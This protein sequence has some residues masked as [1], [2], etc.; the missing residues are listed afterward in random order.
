M[1]KKV[2]AAF[3]LMMVLPLASQAI[4]LTNAFVTSSTG[5]STIAVGDTITY[6]VSLSLTDGNPYVIGTFSLTGDILGTLPSTKGSGWLGVENHVSNWQW[7]YKSGGSNQVKFATNGVIT[8]AITVAPHG[9]ER[10]LAQSYGIFGETGTTGNGQTK[11]MGTVTITASTSGSYLGGAFM[12]PLVDS[13][14]GSA[15]SEVAPIEGAAFTVIPEPGT[16]LL[17]LLGLG[18]LGVMGRKK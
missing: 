9:P 5:S 17:M 12:Y 1:F 14:N 10:R 11:V 2:L 8:P 13:W 3:A 7:N 16:A 15:G 18:G 4:T 6:E